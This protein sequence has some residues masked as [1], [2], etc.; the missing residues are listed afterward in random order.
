MV[1]VYMIKVVNVWYRKIDFYLA[2]LCLTFQHRRNKDVLPAI[3]T[4]GLKTRGRGGGRHS[5]KA[6]F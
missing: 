3:K 6:G 4:G 1:M 5:Q 2:K